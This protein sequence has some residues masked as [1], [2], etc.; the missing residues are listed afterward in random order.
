MVIKNE[1]GV[2]LF[3]KKLT[4]KYYDLI[5]FQKSTMKVYHVLK[6]CIQ[7]TCSFFFL[8]SIPGADPI[9]KGRLSLPFAG[10]PL[11]DVREAVEGWSEGAPVC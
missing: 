1:C 2:F 9:F 3:K 7:S 11:R 5:I 6:Y 4:L 8:L 10:K